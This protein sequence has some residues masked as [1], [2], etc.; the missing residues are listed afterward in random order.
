MGFAMKLSLYLTP[1]DAPLAVLNLDAPKT[2]ADVLAEVDA[3]H[4]FADGGK[5][6]LDGVL[7]APDTWATHLLQPSAVSRC[8][9]IYVPQ[10]KKTLALVASVAVVAIAA[11]VSGGALGPAGLGLLGSSFAAGGI[12][13]S[14]AG[15]AIGIAGSLAVSALTAPPKV[16]DSGADRT[17][18]DAGVT[19]NTLTLLDVLPVVLGKIG[20]SPPLLAPPYTTLEGDDVTLHMIV[21]CEGRNLIENIRINDVDAANIA[22]LAIET[23]ESTTGSEV[24]TAYPGLVIEERNT[25]TLGN[26]QTELAVTTNDLLKDQTTPD[27]SAPGWQYFQTAGDWDE[28]VLRFL[29]PSGMVYVLDGGAVVVPARIEVRKVGDV[30]WRALPTVHFSDYRK[31]NGPMRAEVRL[32]RKKQPS[33][34]YVTNANDEY[35]AFEITNITA[36]GQSFQYSSDAYFIDQTS[37]STNSFIPVMTAATTS[38]YTISASS[39]F[40]A[41]NAGW[42]IADATIV[43]GTFWRPTASSLPAW[44]QF[45]LPS[46]VTMRSFWILLNAASVDYAPKTF[47]WEAWDGAAWVRIDD[48]DHDFDASKTNYYGHIANPMAS[49]KYR[50]NVTS[51]NGAALDDVRIYLLK[52]LESDA[53][54]TD[55][56]NVISSHAAGGSRC[57]NGEIDENGA[58]YYLDPA[59]WPAGVYDIRV[60]RGVASREIWFTESD[61]AYNTNAVNADFFEYRNVSGK[62]KIFIGQKDFRSDC[63]IEAIQTKR[64]VPP[65]TQQGLSVIAMSVPNLQVSSVYGEFT[66]YAPVFDGTIWPAEEVPTQNPAALYRKLL[67][68]GW[69]QSPVPGESIDEDGLAA[70]FTTCAGAAHVCNAVL[71]GARIDEAK[72]MLASAG[73]ASPRNAEVYGVIED[74]DTSALPVRYA[75]TPL[76]S[77]SQGD[78]LAFVTLPDAIRAEFQNEDLKYAVDHLMIYREG[79]TETNAKRIDRVTYTGITDSAKITARASFDLRQAVLRQQRFVRKLGLDGFLLKRGDVVM[80]WDDVVDRAVLAGFI[81]AVT[82]SGGFITALTLDNIMPWSAGGDLL[83]AGDM[84]NMGD[85]LNPSE[86]MGLAI[87]IPGSD[88]VQV[89]VT[90][91][92]DSNTCT[93]TTPLADDGSI[94]PG[95]MVGA[96]P[97]GR[98]GRRVKVM[99]IRPNGF[100]ERTLELADEA[101]ELFT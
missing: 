91:V 48:V 17:L 78:T 51:N 62:Y 11:F 21:G 39:E 50:F 9:F 28:F 76:N 66:S 25:A 35:P 15:T 42:K 18:Q 94:V 79:K 88:V 23:V 5:V 54:A 3:G 37:Y 24:F 74:K 70:W 8:E 90:D 34:T 93:L 30:A 31:G 19:G 49:T 47:Y 73:Y 97:W 57:L 64:D 32:K 85:F 13:A 86:P 82:S 69:S 84:L 29:F 65:F 33:G 67:L 61:Y 71:Q 87:E 56:T 6:L 68:G 26:F 12:G 10:S 101:I 80:L 14:L 22:G 20:F 41:A 40:S 46:A 81:S 77:Q 52:L 59:E 98:I 72:Q 38:G 100:E 16:G 36:R 45:D 44:V 58:T 43:G 27:N 95:L 2:I 4:W 7:I 96:G 99:S 1:L 92:T 53:S 60:K 75:I 55:L 89:Q 83:N 63:S